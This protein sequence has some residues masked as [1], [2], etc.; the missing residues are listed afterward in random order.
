MG[1]SLISLME[2]PSIE[3]HKVNDLEYNVKVHSVSAQFAECFCAKK[4]LSNDSLCRATTK[5]S[6]RERSENLVKLFIE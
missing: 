5:K 3:Q 1:R 6:R 4:A 2:R